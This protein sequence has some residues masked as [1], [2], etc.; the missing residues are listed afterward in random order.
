[1]TNLLTNTLVTV[2]LCITGFLV[3]LNVACAILFRKRRPL[4]ILF[5]VAAALIE[6][7]IFVVALLFRVGVLTHLPYHLPPGLPFDL[8]EIGAAIAVG[9]GLFPVSFWHRTSATQIRARI[10]RDTQDMQNHQASVRVR[11]NAPGEWMN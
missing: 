4:E 7:G 2:T 3:L 5:Y 9:I 11:S 10:A 6:L 8:A 1:M